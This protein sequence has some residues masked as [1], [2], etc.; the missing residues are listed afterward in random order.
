MNTR[1]LTIKEFA[2]KAKV[3]PQIIYKRIQDKNNSLYPF[4]KVID[5]KKYISEEALKIIYNISAES[6]QESEKENNVIELLKKELESK[7]EQINTLLNQLTEA[8]TLI[9]QQQQLH[10]LDKQKIKELE[11]AKEEKKKSVFNFFHFKKR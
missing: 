9:N 4:L 8:H 10:L 2:E 11:E 7:N 6:G 1:Y 3:S 5:G